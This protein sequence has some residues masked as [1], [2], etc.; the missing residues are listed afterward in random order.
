[1]E[2]APTRWEIP[3][4]QRDLP[5]TPLNE[6]LS[7]ERRSTFLLGVPF[8]YGRYFVLGDVAVHTCTLVVRIGVHKWA[9]FKKGENNKIKNHSTQDS[10]VVPH[11]GTN[12]AVLCLTLE[13]G[14]DPVLSKS[15]GRGYKYLQQS[16]YMH[17]LILKSQP[18]KKKKKNRFAQVQRTHPRVGMVKS[19]TKVEQIFRTRA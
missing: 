17:H 9:P 18:K 8:P 16:P 4:R 10:R 13:I 1:L 7:I 3:P 19:P 11:R 5:G 14:R 15:Y 6:D 12:W 2:G